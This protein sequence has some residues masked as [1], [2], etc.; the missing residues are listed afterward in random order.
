MAK[1]FLVDIC[2]K[3]MKLAMACNYL[4]PLTAFINANLFEMS[5]SSIYNDLITKIED[6]TPVVISYKIYETS[7]RRDP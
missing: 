6:L 3:F 7:L 2:I 4:K 5:L 1:Q